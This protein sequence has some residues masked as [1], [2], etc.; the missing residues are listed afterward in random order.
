MLENRSLQAVQQDDMLKDTSFNIDVRDENLG[1]WAISLTSSLVY[2]S[3]RSKL[4]MG[5][6]RR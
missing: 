2:S 3:G 5:G 6:R 1:H 4:R